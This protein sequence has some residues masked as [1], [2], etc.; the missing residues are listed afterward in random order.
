[1]N[2]DGFIGIIKLFLR[3]LDRRKEFTLIFF[4]DDG[5]LGP[6]EE[7]HD[8]DEGLVDHINGWVNVDREGLVLVI[9]VNASL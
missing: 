2:V 1:M 9:H 7:E 8:V 6:V 3:Y 4:V 5:H